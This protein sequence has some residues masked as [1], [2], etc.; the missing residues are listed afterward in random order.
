MNALPNPT[1]ESKNM[2][3]SDYSKKIVKLLAKKPA[4]SLSSLTEQLTN[5]DDPKALY[6]FARSIKGLKDTGLIVGHHSG[7]KE[8]ARL[9]KEGK[10]KAISLKL[11]SETELLNPNWDGKWRIIILDIPEERKTER[12][13]LRYLLKKAGF[14]CLKNSVWISIHPFEYMF[15]NIKRD[16]GLTTEIM[17]FVTDTIDPATEEAFIKNPL[18]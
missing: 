7:Q 2:S 9:T 14:V 1:T 4:I 17:I 6:A 3:K 15:M 11:D 18:S 16:L 5:N 10:K 12:D 13:G 8:Y